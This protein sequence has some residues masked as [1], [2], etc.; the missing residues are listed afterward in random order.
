MGSGTGGNA[1]TDRTDTESTDVRADS[2]KGETPTSNTDTAIDCENAA[3]AK[4]IVNP[5]G[6]GTPTTGPDTPT[7][8]PISEEYVVVTI[9]ND[10]DTEITVTGYV[11]AADGRQEFSRNVSAIAEMRGFRFGSFGHHAIADYGF[12]ITGC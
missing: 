6:R 7:P 10:R 1:P 2:S 4:I 8:A 9:R 11:E 3:I 5:A 12:R